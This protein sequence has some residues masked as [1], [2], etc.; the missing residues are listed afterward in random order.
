MD[1]AIIPARGGSKRIRGK[2]IKLFC[3]KPMIEWSIDAAMNSECFSHVVVSTDD[4]KI[5]QV[6]ENAGASVP[7]MRPIE[8][9]DDHTPTVPVICHAIE[10]LRREGVH[11]DTTSC[12]YA[13]APFLRSEDIQAAFK[14]Y[15]STRCDYVMGVCEY[16]FPVQRA[17]KVMDDGNLIFIESDKFGIRS[18]DLTKAYHDAGQF[19]L[20]RT[21][22][23]FEIHDAL[24][25]KS[26][27]LHLPRE[28]VQDID[29][30]ED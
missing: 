28:R 1:V 11:P 4:E 27:G 16:S 13:T 10:W 14:L 22:V 12:V 29:T 9:S 24:P 5:A 26:R 7:F 8:L 25:E 2:N 3:G 20:A 30:T 23:W 6:A 19:Y 21:A 15:K 17:L 18:Q